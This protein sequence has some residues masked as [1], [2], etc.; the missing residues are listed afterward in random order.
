M[1]TR[2]PDRRAAYLAAKCPP[3]LD[4]DFDDEPEQVT[5][6]WSAQTLPRLSDRQLERAA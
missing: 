5:A 2:K 4:P 3:L 6:R 1:S